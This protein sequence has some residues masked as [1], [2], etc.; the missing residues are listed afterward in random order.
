MEPTTVIKRPLVTEK[1]TWE[2]ESRNRYTFEVDMRACKP[3]IRRA[4]EQ[5]YNVR[6]DA[7]STQVRKGSYFRTRFGTAKSSS[8]KKAVV[9][10]H[11][12]DRIELF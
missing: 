1:S 4:V 7:V 10:L 12:E 5:L 8:W 11:V 3:Q 6:V 9:Q 2:T